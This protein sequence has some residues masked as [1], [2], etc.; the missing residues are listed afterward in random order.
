RSIIRKRIRWP[1]TPCWS[2]DRAQR[3]PASAALFEAGEF[4]R[5]D[6]ADREAVAAPLD[7]AQLL[8]FGRSQRHHHPPTGGKL[9][10]QRR[11]RLGGGGGDEDRI[12]RRTFGPSA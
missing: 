4:R 9:I 5:H 11:R 12:V 7:H 10:D 6:R 2:P 1:W 3:A 8:H